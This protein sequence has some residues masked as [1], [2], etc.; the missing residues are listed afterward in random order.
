MHTWAQHAIFTS[1]LTSA[2]SCGK[3]Y[4]L[5]MEAF[6]FRYNISFIDHPLGLD[7]NEMSHVVTSEKDI[8]DI[9]IS[10][11]NLGLKYSYN[12]LKFRNIQYHKVLL[13][14]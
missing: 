9:L 7:R 10:P 2:F 4:I 3:L 6:N 5:N 8:L 13:Q 14:F 1:S 12:I 11:T